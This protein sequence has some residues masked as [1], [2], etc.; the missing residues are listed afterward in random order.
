MS[1]RYEQSQATDNARGTDGRESP[2]IEVSR[3][4]A[5]A[6]L[7]LGVTFAY[8]AP[9]LMNLNPAAAHHKKKKNED[10]GSGASC[11][12]GGSEP[13]DEKQA[14]KGE[15]ATESGIPS[16]PSAPKDTI[17]AIEAEAVPDAQACGGEGQPPC[18]SQ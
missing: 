12:S 4:Q 3:R 11:A 8:A 18:Q 16:A 6:R 10:G 5:L 13:K 7:G 17:D 9:A 15:D 14:M 2:R 1:D